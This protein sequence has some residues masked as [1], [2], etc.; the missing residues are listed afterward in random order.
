MST[1]IP[2]FFALL[3]PL[4]G[5]ATAPA[6]PELGQARRLAVAVKPQRLVGDN[7]RFGDYRAHEL[8]WSWI[9]GLERTAVALNGARHGLVAYKFQFSNGGEERWTTRCLTS[10]RDARPMPMG[11]GWYAGSAALSCTFQHSDR[12]MHGSLLLTPAAWTFEKSRAVLG[13]AVLEL[14]PVATG[15]SGEPGFYRIVSHGR[16]V[17]IVDPNRGT[18]QVW[19]SEGLDKDTRMAV[20]ISASTLLLF[21]DLI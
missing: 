7:L 6:Y 5:C 8:D 16:P 14:E 21:E 18:G 19:I 2:R 10:S 3:L 11:S 4:V 9:D 15:S 20:A 13:D 12:A 1:P 17:G